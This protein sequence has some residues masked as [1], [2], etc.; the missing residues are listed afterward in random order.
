MLYPYKTCLI[1]WL[2]HNTPLMFRFTAK[3]A[4]VI[5]SA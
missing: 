5:A 4:G 1:R 3:A 2:S